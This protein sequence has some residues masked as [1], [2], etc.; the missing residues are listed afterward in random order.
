MND[1]RAVQSL[2]APRAHMLKRCLHYVFCVHRQSPHTKSHYL[3]LLVSNSIACHILIYCQSYS[4]IYYL[5]NKIVIVTA[6]LMP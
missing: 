3:Y 1:L 5:A 4:N 6:L 2:N